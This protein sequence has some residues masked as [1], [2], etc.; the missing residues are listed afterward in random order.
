VIKAAGKEEARKKEIRT[1]HEDGTSLKMIL[2]EMITD[3]ERGVGMAW[4]NPDGDLLLES[5]G[6]SDG[7]CKR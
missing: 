3:A 2:I 6:E 7:Q 5:D 1:R 4:T